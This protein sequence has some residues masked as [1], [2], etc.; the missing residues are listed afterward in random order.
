M[1]LAVFF[2]PY[3]KSQIFLFNYE[4][5]IHIKTSVFMQLMNTWQKTYYN[6]FF[7]KEMCWLAKVILFFLFKVI[8]F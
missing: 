5:C 8:F 4:L 7:K 3:F 1:L 6:E 2:S